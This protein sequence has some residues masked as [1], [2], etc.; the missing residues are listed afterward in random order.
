MRTVQLAIV[1]RRYADQIREL[2]LS[3]GDHRVYVVDAPN[4]KIDGVIAM[5]EGLVADLGA[6]DLD[7]C[8]IVAKKGTR[9]IASLF[10]AGVRHLV[11]STDSPRTA[12][13][14]ILATELRLA[15]GSMARSVIR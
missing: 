7:R 3:D 2:L 9:R 5:D 12:R 1:D 8:V 15:Q 6:Y 10:E 11:F 13:L 4:P 14:A